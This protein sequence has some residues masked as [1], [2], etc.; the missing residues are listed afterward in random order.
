MASPRIA[1]VTLVAESRAPATARDSVGKSSLRRAENAGTKMLDP[2]L[3]TMIQ[4]TSRGSDC[5]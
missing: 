5:Q 2:K 1:P 3:P 4:K